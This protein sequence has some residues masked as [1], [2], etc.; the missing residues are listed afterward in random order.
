MLHNKS[1]FT[2]RSPGTTTTRGSKG[3]VARQQRPSAA[4]RK[5]RIKKFKKWARNVESTGERVSRN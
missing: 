5:K 4:K 1:S 3:V 2:M